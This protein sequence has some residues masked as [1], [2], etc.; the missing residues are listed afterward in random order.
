MLGYRKREDFLFVRV[1]DEIRNRLSL[2][3][4][5]PQSHDFGCVSDD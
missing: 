5:T 2:V 4:D 3:A 1:S